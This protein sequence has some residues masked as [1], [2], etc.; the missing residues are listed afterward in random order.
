VSTS[1][2]ASSRTI[3]CVVALSGLASA[4]AAITLPVTAQT[5]EIA[6]ILAV[7][8]L[9]LL[10]GHGWGLPVVTLAE[11]VLLGRLC[12]LVV[13]DWPPAPAVQI[14]TYMALLGALPGLVL[15][16]RGLPH[17]VE[18]VL[19]PQCAPRLRLAGVALGAALSGMGLIVPL[20]QL[21]V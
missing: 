3:T 21:A 16:R 19:G 15:L 18:L 20:W 7:G 14:A 17:A 5:A 10:A 13:Y 12:P 8:A 4:L 11:V 6:S 2:P 9:A 1:V